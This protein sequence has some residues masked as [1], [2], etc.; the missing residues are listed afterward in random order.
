MRLARPVA[1]MGKCVMQ[2]KNLFMKVTGK[3]L[4]GSCA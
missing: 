4:I 3:D 2:I 1:Y